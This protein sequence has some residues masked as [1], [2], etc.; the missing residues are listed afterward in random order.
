MKERRLET[1]E[2]KVLQVAAMEQMEGTSSFE[3][4]DARRADGRTSTHEPDDD[5]KDDD[6]DASKSIFSTLFDE[7]QDL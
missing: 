1:Q 6:D 3:K 2:L 4:M 7:L 5:D